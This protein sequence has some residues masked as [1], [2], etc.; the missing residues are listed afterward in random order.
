MARIQELAWRNHARGARPGVLR[1]LPHAPSTPVTFLDFNGTEEHS[2]AFAAAVAQA[3]PQVVG[4][5]RKCWLELR[6]IWSENERVIVLPDLEEVG[7]LVMP[8]GYL[9]E[10]RDFFLKRNKG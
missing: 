9:S 2:R 5:F 8:F 6:E 7:A 1:T 3:P 10:N 4:D